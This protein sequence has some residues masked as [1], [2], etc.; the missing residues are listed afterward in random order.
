MPFIIAID[1][2][3]HDNLSL[4]YG[5]YR[6]G[7]DLINGISKIVTGNR[8]VVIGSQPKPPL[9]IAHIFIDKNLN[10]EY[11]CFSKTQ[12]RLGHF[13]DQWSFYKMIAKYRP[14]LIHCLGNFIPFIVPCPVVATFHDL[15]EETLKGKGGGGGLYINFIKR[16]GK[17]KLAK[18]I[19]SSNQTAIDLNRYWKIRREAIKTIHL[20]TSFERKYIGFSE[21]QSDVIIARFNLFP[22]KNMPALLVALSIVDKHGY[23]PKLVLFG[24]ADVGLESEKEFDELAKNLSLNERII[25]TG[26]LSDSELTKLYDTATML[27]VPSLTEG[28]GLPLIEAMSRALPVVTNR[29]GATAEVVGDGGVLVDVK[30]PADLA[31]GIINLL[32]NPLEQQRIGKA[33]FCRSKYFASDQ[34]ALNTFNLYMNIINDTN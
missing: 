15:Y 23:R 10:W 21:R 11:V 17:W 8:F 26:F 28:F 5:F 6:Y 9:E 34:M 27:V 30:D 14:K 25:K 12:K 31:N 4:A 7:I 2:S 19:A 3:M 22:G 20:G 32:A 33:G 29:Y 1:F 18:F 24:K 13:R 16:F